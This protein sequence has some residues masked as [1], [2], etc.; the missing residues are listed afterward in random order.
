V[1]SP[2]FAPDFVGPPHPASGGW[3]REKQVAGWAVAAAALI[4][5]LRKP[6]GLITPQL[7]AEDGPIHLADVDS[8]GAH[9]FFVPYRGYLHLLPRLIAWTANHLTDVAHWPLFYNVAA[10]LVVVALLAR[11]A[12]RRL[13]LPGK[14]WL[15]LSFVLA[16]HTGEVWFNI[17]NLH[18]LTAFFLVQHVLIARPVTR[19]QRFGDLSILAVVGLTGPFVVVFLP[20]FVWRWWR[21]RHVDNLAVLLTAAGCAAVQVY[22]IQ[23]SGLTLDPQSRP[24]NLEML[25]A[26]TGSRLVVWPLFGSRIA[27]TLS[28]PALGVIGVT[29]IAVLLGWALR[30]DPRRLLRAQVVAAFLLMTGVCLWRIRPDA[31]A[32]PDLVN[33]DSYFYVPR[34]LLLW[35]LIWEFD[36]RPRQVAFAARALALISVVLQLPSYKLSP[37]PDYHWAETMPLLFALSAV[38]SVFIWSRL[39]RTRSPLRAL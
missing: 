28:W 30:P 27:E 13:D 11:L 34:I 9:A 17:T 16:A 37:P 38:K 14:P 21:D 23:T 25:L 26:V 32:S 12:S 10:F 36:S 3:W 7:W 29:F 31:W 33:G 39:R 19:V 5:F 2:P 4:L 8:W 1:N 20:L 6:W 24:L 18:W 15:I 35:S 22:F